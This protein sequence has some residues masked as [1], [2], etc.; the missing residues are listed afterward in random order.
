[1]SGPCSEVTHWW[2][3]V[4]K[5]RVLDV[6]LLESNNS[7][8]FSWILRSCK[9]IFSLRLEWLSNWTCLES[10]GHETDSDFCDI[11]S[12]VLPPAL[13]TT[14]S[15][16]SQVIKIGSSQPKLHFSSK[17]FS[18]SRFYQWVQ[19]QVL[20]FYYIMWAICRLK[21]STL[22]RLLSGIFHHLNFTEEH[23]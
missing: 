21:I 8:H 20:G 1:M 12:G 2:T 22:A 7:I 23:K 11:G 15:A 3:D 4:P 6:T 18:S 10:G 19:K 14:L 13:I 16:F 17:T 5:W 9:Q